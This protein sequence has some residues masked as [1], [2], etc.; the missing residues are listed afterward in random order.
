VE[1]AATASFNHAVAWSESGFNDLVSL[2]G[3]GA[4]NFRARR[5]IFTA[6]SEI[7]T[8]FTLIFIVAITIRRSEATG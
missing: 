1:K 2:S 4:I 6:K 7:R 8:R 3:D 5:A